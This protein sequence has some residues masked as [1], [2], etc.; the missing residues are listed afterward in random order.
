MP[1]FHLHLSN[2]L[3]IL[4]KNLAEVVSVTSSSPLESEVIV[5][6]NQGME[7]WL[8]QQ[9]AVR[10]G[11]W[12][13]CRFPFP[14]NIV[15]ELFHCADLRDYLNTPFTTEFMTWKIFSVLENYLDKGEFFALKNFLGNTP[16]YLCQG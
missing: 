11:I 4:L 12:A 3:E 5:V 10:L 13:N 15:E 9:L 7:K 2:K 6:Q 1:G 16:E 8:T 14:N